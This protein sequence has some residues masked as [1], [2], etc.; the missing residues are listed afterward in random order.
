MK[1]AAN[2]RPGDAVVAIKLS[3]HQALGNILK[4]G[5]I[6]VVKPSVESGY[7]QLIGIQ[8]GA[9]KPELFVPACSLAKAIYGYDE[10][11]F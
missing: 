11:A 4:L 9:Y 3:G 1:P 7:I 6:Y 2:Y 8:F 5:R 10:E